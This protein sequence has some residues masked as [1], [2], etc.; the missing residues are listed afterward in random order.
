MLA[1]V[2][3]SVEEL[4]QRVL[5]LENMLSIVQQEKANLE[6]DFRHVL[7]LQLVRKPIAYGYNR[8]I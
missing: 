4:K 1:G 5:K 6:D 2:R 8:E 3:D 7:E